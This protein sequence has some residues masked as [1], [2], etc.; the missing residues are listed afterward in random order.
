M[1]TKSGSQKR[2]LG[3]C[4]PFNIDR[5]NPTIKEDGCEGTLM[6]FLPSR[7]LAQ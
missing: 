2:L 1:S 4:N 5:L 6:L 3:A 7:K